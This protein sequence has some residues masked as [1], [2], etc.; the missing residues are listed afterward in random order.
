MISSG[1]HPFG[2]SL[3]RQANILAGAYQLEQFQEETHGKEAYLRLAEA[4]S[5]IRTGGNVRLE[6]VRPPLGSETWSHVPS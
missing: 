5:F 3:R 4:S 6:N 1:K 2:D